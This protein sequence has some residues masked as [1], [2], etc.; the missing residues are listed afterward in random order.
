MKDLKPLGVLSNG[1]GLCALQMQV[2]ILDMRQTGKEKNSAQQPRATSHLVTLA[3]LNTR[4]A[5]LIETPG[6]G[7]GAL[8][9]V[10]TVYSFV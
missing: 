2:Y 4:G 9:Y 5:V 7:R 3:P 10:Y 8:R 6:P 1:K